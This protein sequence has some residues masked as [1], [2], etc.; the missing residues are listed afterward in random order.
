MGGAEA[1]NLRELTDLFDDA[2]REA[3]SVPDI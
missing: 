1:G 2:T 3:E